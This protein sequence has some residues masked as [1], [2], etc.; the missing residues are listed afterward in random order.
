MKVR[1][2]VCQKI[3]AQGVTMSEVSTDKEMLDDRDI[4]QLVPNLLSLW[5]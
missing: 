3:I 4:E 1:T 5:I 2:V